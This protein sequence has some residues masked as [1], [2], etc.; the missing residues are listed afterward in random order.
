MLLKPIQAKGASSDKVFE[1]LDTDRDEKIT[2]EEFFKVLPRLQ[3]RHTCDDAFQV[4]SALPGSAITREQVASSR[5][6]FLWKRIKLL[7]ALL[8]GPVL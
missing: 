4:V 3:P 2:A 7:F 6:F 5:A 8:G 1:L